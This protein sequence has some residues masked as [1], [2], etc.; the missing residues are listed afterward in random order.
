M[1]AVLK[2]N[3]PEDNYEFNNAINGTKLRCILEDVD[4]YLRNK[5]KYE[6]LTEDQNDIYQDVRDYLY[7][8]LDEENI[9]L[10]E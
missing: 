5:L 1:K 2:Y 4:T 3:L 9:R 6:S 10:F 8:L 7:N